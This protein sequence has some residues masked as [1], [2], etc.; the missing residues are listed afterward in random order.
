MI[1]KEHSGKKNHVDPIGK[2]FAIMD[3]GV[4]ES[5]QGLKKTRISFILKRGSDHY[6]KCLALNATL[7]GH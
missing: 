2:D 3:L 1:I 7:I 5:L 6:S 4:S